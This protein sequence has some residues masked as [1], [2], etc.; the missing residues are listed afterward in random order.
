MQGDP[1]HDL[2]AKFMGE[3]EAVKRTSL[4]QDRLTADID[5]LVQLI[6]RGNYRAAV[7]LTAQLLSAHG[8][9]PGMSG[10]LTANTPDTLQ[11]GHQSL[12]PMISKSLFCRFS[13][14]IMQINCCFIDDLNFKFFS[15]GSSG[16]HY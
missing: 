15:C 8:Q 3:H 10:H 11:A 14:I 1:V 7:D 13:Q 16:W 4:I 5:G 2:V 6:N 12:V 9:G